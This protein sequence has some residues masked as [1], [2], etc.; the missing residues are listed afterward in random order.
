MKSGSPSH[1][2]DTTQTINTERNASAND[3]S[4]PISR[5]KFSPTLYTKYKK[6]EQEKRMVAKNEFKNLVNKITDKKNWKQRW[7]KIKQFIE[8]NRQVLAHMA[9]QDEGDEQAEAD[10]MAHEKNQIF[11]LIMALY[12][13]EDEHEVFR[14]LDILYQRHPRE[15]EFY[16][17]QLCTYL[18]HF[19]HARIERKNSDA[20]AA[21]ADQDQNQEQRESS[22]TKPD[23]NQIVEK[24][25]KEDMVIGRP[26][27]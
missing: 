9:R 12:A 21:P 25:Q 15:V 6:M 7:G 2:S 23:D 22:V 11:T 27:N 18:F 10:F 17:P 26:S 8:T 4:A 20:V 19:S 16:I 14:D 3:P 24:N 1:R 13:G 5:M